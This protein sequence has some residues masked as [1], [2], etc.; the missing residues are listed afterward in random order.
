MAGQKEMSGQKMDFTNLNPM[1]NS[2]AQRFIPLV[3]QDIYQVAQE[4][5]ELLPITAP[6]G[7]LGM[8]VQTYGQQK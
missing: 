2:I 4:E 1:N 8:G 6:L 3:M 5:P 7:I